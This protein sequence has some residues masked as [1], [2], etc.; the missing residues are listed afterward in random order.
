M[1]LVINFLIENARKEKEKKNYL[2]NATN[3]S[4]QNI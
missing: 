1:S 2:Y 3:K 4:K